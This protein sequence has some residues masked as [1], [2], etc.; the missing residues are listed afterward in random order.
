MTNDQIAILISTASFVLAAIALGWNV[1]RDIILKPRL[2]VSVNHVRMHVE[3]RKPSS[4]FLVSAVNFGPGK[5]RL[6][7]V[8]FKESSF[9]KR[10][11]KK[12]KFG[13]LIHDY[14]NPLSGKLPATLDVG[15]K[16]DLV[17]PWD[18]DCLAGESPTHIGI[19]DSFGRFHWAPSKDVKK[20][21][22]DWR[23]SFVVE[24]K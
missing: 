6:G 24:G 17:F 11:F 10:I 5:I 13:F 21:K 16:I 15:E 18:E 3:G 1:Y 9:L 2:R 20:V 22:E 4:K 7:M 14:K 8:R 12:L 19:L 23:K